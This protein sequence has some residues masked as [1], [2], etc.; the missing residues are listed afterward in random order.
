MNAT[1]FSISSPRLVLSST[2]V[3]AKFVA[4]TVKFTYVTPPEVSFVSPVSSHAVRSIST[5]TGTFWVSGTWNEST[6]VRSNPSVAFR[7]RNS[8][9]RVRLCANTVFTGM[10]RDASSF[11]CPSTIC[12]PPRNRLYSAKMTMSFR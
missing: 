1:R 3:Y 8:M 12:A 6:L 9:N 11:P 10:P 4:D 5:F 7:S 2:C